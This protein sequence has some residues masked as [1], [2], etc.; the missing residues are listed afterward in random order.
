MKP[1]SEGLH[2][3]DVGAGFRWNFRKF[4]CE[5]RAAA[6]KRV[7]QESL[8]VRKNAERRAGDEPNDRGA[9]IGSGG[10]VAHQGV[11]EDRIGEE[12]ENRCRDAKRE[13]ER[14][15]LF[16]RLGRLA[17]LLRMAER[18]GGDGRD[19]MVTATS[20]SVMRIRIA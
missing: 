15:A 9:D 8:R 5:N 17:I 19:A 16:D 14:A 11:K 7:Q 2:E 12:A 3:Q 6:S 1:E 20:S 4:P 10:G 18:D 13:G